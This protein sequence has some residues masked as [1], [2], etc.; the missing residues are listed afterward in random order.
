MV[1]IRKGLVTT[2]LNAKRLSPRLRSLDLF[3]QP[4]RRA[5]VILSKHNYPQP[6]R[7]ASILSATII[8]LQSFFGLPGPEV[9]GYRVQRAVAQPLRHEL[10]HEQQAKQNGGQV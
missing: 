5:D 6:A 10:Y 4:D 8:C 9:M 3:I 7:N 2:Y 1:I